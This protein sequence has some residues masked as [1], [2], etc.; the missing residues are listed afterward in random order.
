MFM[1]NDITAPSKAPHFRKA[2]IDSVKRADQLNAVVNGANAS[3]T[4]IKRLSEF[5]IAPVRD[6]DDFKYFTQIRAKPIFGFGGCEFRSDVPV[7][8][9]HDLDVDEVAERILEEARMFMGLRG[10]GGAMKRMRG[11]IDGILAPATTGLCPMRF[12]ALGLTVA[13]GRFVVDVETLGHDLMSGIERVHHHD[14]DGLR[15]CLESLVATHVIR[16]GLKIAAMA[17]RAIGWIDEAAL[18]ILDGSGMERSDAIARLRNARSLEFDFGGDKGL[19]LNAE[20]FWEDGVIKGYV[21][22]FAE[23]W[24]FSTNRLIARAKDVPE[25]VLAAWVGRRFGDLMEHSFVP[26][27][28]VVT[29]VDSTAEELLYVDLVIGTLLVDERTGVHLDMRIS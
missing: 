24:R 12:V 27:D 9:S 7:R 28:A 19:D 29:G 13:D 16:Q 21:G 17:S 8:D 20:L 15:K 4:G 1:Q 6:D 3:R 22:C 18:R 23:D 26:A 2:H 11:M 5:S 25:T 14:Y 10:L